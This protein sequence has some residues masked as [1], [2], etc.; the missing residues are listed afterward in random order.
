MNGVFYE[1][2]PAGSATSSSNPH[3][4]ILL[5]A[6]GQSTRMGQNKQLLPWRGKT[7]LHAVCEALR[8]GWDLSNVYP[9]VG[10]YPFVAVTGYDHKLLAPIVESYGFSTVWNLRPEN[11]QGVSV[12]LGVQ[13]LVN[14]EWLP[15][16]GIICSV[17]D[18][19]LLTP[20]VI[21][22]LINAFQNQ[23]IIERR[24]GEL[25]SK[26]IVMP[27]YGAAYTPGN[28]VLF[29]AH[30]FD[31]LC[32]IEGDQGGKTIIQGPGRD[33][34]RNIWIPADIGDD[35]DTPTDYER[36]GNRESEDI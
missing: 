25:P 30:W 1:S 14:Q 27:H 8:S 18:Q 13:Q 10:R 28:P 33:Y 35:V 2:A 22:E 24:D 31:A 34:I 17:A 12:G 29:G 7:V 26:T 23:W 11:G 32:H 6:A 9:P 21:C 20:F 5:L 15:L 36:I 16:D 3:I 4:G 19:P